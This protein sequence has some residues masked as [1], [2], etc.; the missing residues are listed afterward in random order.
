[1]NLLVGFFDFVASFA[2]RTVLDMEI[3]AGKQTIAVA[4]PLLQIWRHAGQ[5]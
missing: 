5:C 2:V 4:V 1:M 3:D